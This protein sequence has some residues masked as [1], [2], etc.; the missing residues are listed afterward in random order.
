VLDDASRGFVAPGQ[1]PP[2]PDPAPPDPKLAGSI[3][4]TVS[5]GVKTIP[6]RLYKPAEADSGQELPLILF[7]HGKG[8]RGTDNILQTTWLGN[9][10]KATRSGQYAAYVLAPQIDPGMWFQSYTSSPTEAMRLTIRALEQVMAGENVDP[11]RVYVTGVSMGGMGAWD[12]LRW[13]PN[14]FAAAVPMSGGADPATAGAIKDVPVWAFHGTNDTVVPVS[15][16]RNIIAA[17]R[18]AGGSPK[19]TEIAGG[20]H[21]IWNGVYADSSNTLY[22]WLFSQR[23]PAAPAP[24]PVFSASRITRA[25]PKPRAIV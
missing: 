23:R 19:Y 24:A 21:V 5:D 16:T 3:G 25:K 13:E 4:G 2:P 15:A 11:A 8:E 12:I 17:L 1:Q 14:L 18:A 9:L 22:P 20:G 10:V 6:Y 7:L